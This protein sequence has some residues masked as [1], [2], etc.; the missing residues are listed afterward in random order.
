M[1]I[2]LISNNDSLDW[3]NIPP[4]EIVN[5]VT[6]SVK[7]GSIVLFHNGALNTP[8]ALPKVIENLQ[9][10]GYEIVPVS[11]LIYKDHYTIDHAGMQIKN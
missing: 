4:D 2:I 5:R 6:S 10:R 11:Q 7:P 8:T 9:A 3:K 1:Y